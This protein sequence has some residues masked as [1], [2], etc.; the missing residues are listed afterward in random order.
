MS[1]SL[2]A[3]QPRMLEPSNPSPSSKTSSVS[4]L[5]GMVKCCHS[6]GKSMNRRSTALTS[7]SRQNANTSLG[8]TLFTLSAAIVKAPRYKVGDGWW[9]AMHPGRPSNGRRARLN[10][11]SGIN[12]H[13]RRLPV[14][15]KAG[16]QSRRGVAG[17]GADFWPSQRCGRP[18]GRAEMTGG[19]RKKKPC[20]P[21][22]PTGRGSAI[23]A[24][25]LFDK[26]HLGIGRQR[27]KVV[28]HYRLQ[29]V[30]HFADGLH[31]G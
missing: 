7:F 18:G 26:Q 16:G 14:R 5:T 28:G 25:R 24:I 17:R 30:G 23:L 21:R 31:R 19:R 1:L 29:R 10:A 11:R 2:I 4:L 3:C 13:H 9:P 15:E 27:P 8:V 12:Q 6:P 20:R 22:R